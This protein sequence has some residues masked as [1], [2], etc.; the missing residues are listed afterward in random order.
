G[1]HARQAQG[2]RFFLFERAQRAVER[3]YQLVE[4]RFEI[5]EFADLAA[6][7]GQEVAQNLVFLA[8]ARADV[9]QV[10]DAD[11]VAAVPVSATARFVGPGPAFPAKKV[12]QLRHNDASP[13]PKRLRTAPKRR[14]SKV[15][16]L[17]TFD[18]GNTGP[19]G[20]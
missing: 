5:I 11:G 1:Q 2:L 12:R 18:L 9:R 20:L 6:G 15:T 4:C 3:G 16:I 8:H 14:S 17:Y 10:F 7:V 19:Y 13:T